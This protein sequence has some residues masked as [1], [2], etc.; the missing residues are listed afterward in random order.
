MAKELN[1]SIVEQVTRSVKGKRIL[2]ATTPLD[3]HINPLTG[4][5]VHL[6]NEG[7]D[8]RWYTSVFYK[9]KM[10]KLG[11]PHY[12]FTNAFD[13]R[14]SDD[15]EQLFPER[16]KHKT[17]IAKLNF[18]IE[19]AFIARATEYY[20]D[21]LEIRKEFAFD[22]VV[23]D[24]T[25]TAIPFIT[26]KL[27]IPVINAGIV[28]LLETSKHLPPAGLGMTPSE[29]VLGRIKQDILRY[30]ADKVLFKKSLNALKKLC[31]ENDLSYNG[32][33]IF[34]FILRRSTLVL[35][36]GTPGFEYKRSDIGAHIRFC[37]PLLPYTKASN[38]APWFDE[39][40]NK[41]EKIVLVTQGT[42]ERDIDK[43]I[44]PTIEAFKDTD[45]LVVVT[46]GGSGTEVL[47]ARYPHRN[48]IIEDF[49]P[50]GEVMPYADVYV[51]NGGYG[52]VLLS[53][54]NEVPMVVAGVHEGK[55][56][57]CARVGY[58]NY[59]VNLKTETPSSTQIRSAVTR[60]INNQRYKRNVRTLAREFRQYDTN[61]ITVQ[62]VESLVSH[63]VLQFKEVATA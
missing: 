55:I 3:G 1:T 25:F 35:Q 7:Y 34:D 50:F 43:I 41:Y 28:P 31:V 60:V 42:V 54:E 44:V 59:G 58:F 61:A 19:H 17:Q 36:S 39:R 48:V 16:K 14:G 15:I 20:S 40:L 8:V 22:L 45:V 23:A 32:E 26:E 18:D 57:I 53:I 12:T 51:S 21:I 29:S 33:N 49:I 13:L 63:R 30:I 6:K 24:F 5:A 2:F 37:G 56:E 9:E 10:E 27:E 52:G 47:R 11:I 38:N 46:T 62:C 4:I